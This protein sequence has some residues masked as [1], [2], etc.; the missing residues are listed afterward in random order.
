MMKNG[1]EREDTGRSFI[2]SVSYE[3]TEGKLRG[4]RKKDV[5]KRYNYCHM[6]ETKK[7][8]RIGEEE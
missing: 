2:M 8:Q 3:I 4:G 1:N 6:E 5:N 7:R